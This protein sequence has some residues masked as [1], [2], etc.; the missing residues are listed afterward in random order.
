MVSNI[1]F[2]LDKDAV[3]QKETN[4]K[5]GYTLLQIGPGVHDVTLKGGTYKGD[6]DTHDYSSGGTHE[7]GYGI[8][9]SG[10]SDIMIDDIKATDFTGDGLAVGGM[11]K[12][13]DEFHTESF[14]SGSCLIILASL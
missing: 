4:N 14:K 7:G 13:I 11:G 1:T 2:E 3:L 8:V 10:A 6:K 12:L 5:N 9:T